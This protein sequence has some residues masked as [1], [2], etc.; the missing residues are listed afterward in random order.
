MNLWQVALGALLNAVA[1]DGAES[2]FYPVIGANNLSYLTICYLGMLSHYIFDTQIDYLFVDGTQNTPASDIWELLIGYGFNNQ[3]EIGIIPIT[4][5]ATGN[6]DF[7]RTTQKDFQFANSLLSP[8]ILS[9]QEAGFSKDFTYAD[10][11]KIM[12]WLIVSTYWILLAD[13]GQINPTTYMQ[14]EVYLAVDFNTPRNHPA[15]NNIFVN[16]TLFALYSEIMV[17]DIL[18]VFGMSVSSSDLLPLDDGNRLFPVETTFVQS[19]TCTIKQLKPPLEAFVSIIGAEYVFIKGAYSL[20][21]SAAALYQRR[22]GQE[23]MMGLTH[24][25]I[26]LDNF[27][28]GHS[29]VSCMSTQK[30]G[31][32][33]VIICCRECWDKSSNKNSPV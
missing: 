18:P 15:T 32:D 11:W 8:L 27:C 9:F 7:T 6:I 17:S 31:K 4:F 33:G 5:T 19:Y 22:K 26:L 28:E 13:A 12:N 1:P 24:L 23:C 30:L 20:F 29:A 16:D 21:I 14:E 25:L 2:M 3:S 10:L